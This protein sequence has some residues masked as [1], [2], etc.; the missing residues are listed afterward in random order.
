MTHKKETV[1]ELKKIRDE[2]TEQLIQSERIRSLG[3]LSG[4]VA[5]HFN[6][7]LSVILGYSSLV[8]NTE[9]LTPDAKKA[10]QKI[11]D[12]AQRGRRLT[13]ELLAFAGSEVEEDVECHVHETLESVL[14]LLQS[15]V[16]SRVRVQTDMSAGNDEVFAPQSSVHQI[17][18]NLLTNALDSMP[19]GGEI[20]VSTA[21]VEVETDEGKQEH[22]QIV[23]TDSGTGI[24]DGFKPPEKTDEKYYPSDSV[25]LRLSSVYGIVGKLDGTVLTSSQP[26]A[27]TRVEVLLPTASKRRAGD[28]LAARGKRLTP[29][30]IWVVDDDP[31]FREM[32]SVVLSEQGHEIV[33]LEGGR[34]LQ[35]KWQES[36]Q[37]P[38]LIIIDFSM[39]EYNGLELCTWLMKNESLTPVVLVSGLSVNQPDIKKALDMK[40]T[41]FLQKPFSFRELADVVTV[42]MGET[43]IGE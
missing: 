9:D 27:E 31:V 24:P 33:E 25:G 28:Q 15:Q 23:V 1:E 14:S 16:H 10:L 20:T 3:T 30:M 5:H 18:F 17:V 39:P 19:T 37:K 8:L 13:E 6:N 12:A 42:A 40:R 41:Y 11:T 22:L 35:G 2:L 34:Q 32:C 4:G 36:R 43:L 26:E 7:L 29:S 38:D 21:N